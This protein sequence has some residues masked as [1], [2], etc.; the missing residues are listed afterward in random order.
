M[1]D[2]IDTIEGLGGFAE[3]DCMGLREE[4]VEII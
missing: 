2:E 1:R 4:Q 3:D